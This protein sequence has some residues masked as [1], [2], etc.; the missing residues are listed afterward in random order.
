M[1]S[2]ALHCECKC[3]LISLA[4]H[5]QR[6]KW[7]L[8][9]D[10]LFNVY[11]FDQIQWRVDNSFARLIN[12]LKQLPF[13]KTWSIALV[14][15]R[16]YCNSYN[17]QIGHNVTDRVVYTVSTTL[18]LF[19]SCGCF[20]SDWLH[21]LP[22]FWWIVFDCCHKPAAKPLRTGEGGGE[23]K[24]LTNHHLLTDWSISRPT[25][26]KPH[27]SHAYPGHCW[28]TPHTSSLVKINQP[29]WS[30]IMNSVGAGNQGINP[31]PPRACSQMEGG[32]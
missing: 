8:A 16:T 21:N 27:S 23:A 22:H 30:E 26:S 4:Y 20:V 9:L 24:G 17:R 32:Q 13:Q 28:D 31:G 19:Q 10:I 2:R 6:H 18:L 5:A 7:I 3:S 11:S 29:P 14:N 12:F 25:Q 1:S 15:T